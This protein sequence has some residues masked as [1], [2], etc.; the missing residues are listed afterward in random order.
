MKNNFCCTT[1]NNLINIITINI[2]SKIS[3]KFNQVISTMKSEFENIIDKLSN[4]I[5]NLTKENN[6]DLNTINVKPISRSRTKKVIIPVQETD[7]LTITN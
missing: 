7:A 4:K 3:E 6:T 1:C 5:N 2:E